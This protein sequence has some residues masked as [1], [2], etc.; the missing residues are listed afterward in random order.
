MT[1]RFLSLSCLALLVSLSPLLGQ[2]K[3]GD[4]IRVGMIGLD[5]SHALAFTKILHDPANQ[6]DVRVVAAVPQSSADIESSVTRIDGYVET[7]S[8]DFG[9]EPV[10]DLRNLPGAG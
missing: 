9:A 10:G 2:E 7:L 6:Y 5:T 3:S 1:R 4:P 8:K